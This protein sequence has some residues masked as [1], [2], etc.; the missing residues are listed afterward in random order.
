MSENE[1]LDVRWIRGL[2]EV[3]EREFSVSSGEARPSTGESHQSNGTA[4]PA[5]VKVVGDGRGIFGGKIAIYSPNSS[6]N[7]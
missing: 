1:Q 3:S 2:V 7:Q 5:G 6:G 4:V